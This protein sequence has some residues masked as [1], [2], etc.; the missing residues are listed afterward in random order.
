MAIGTSTNGKV[1]SGQLITDEQAKTIARLW[2]SES[3]EMSAF[4]ESGVI[5]PQLIDALLQDVRLLEAAVAEEDVPPVVARAQLRALLHYMQTY[6]PRG[7]VPFW[8]DVPQVDPVR[9]II[10]PIIRENFDR[11]HSR[12]EQRASVQR[13]AGSRAGGSLS[14]H[15]GPTAG[16]SIYL[17]LGAPAIADVVVTFY[18]MMV[19]DPALAPYFEPY[20]VDEIMSH[21]HAFLC[22]ATG[23]PLDYL[24]RSIRGA[25]EHLAITNEHFDRT[26]EH[27]QAALAGAGVP[28]E[29]VASILA[30][31]EAFRGHVVDGGRA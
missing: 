24:G 29:T 30:K 5:A 26:A 22:A 3:P 27:L 14:V 15:R 11:A 10:E 23:G 16:A 19:G 4:V 20:D 31:V 9:G 8:H 12:F 18:K 7:R 21:Q 1:G 2:A 28:A 25:H 13:T 6:G 17:Q